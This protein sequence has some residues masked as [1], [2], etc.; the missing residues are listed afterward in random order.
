MNVLNLQTRLSTLSLPA[1]MGLP[2]ELCLESG[3][4]RLRLPLLK[5]PGAYPIVLELV[6]Q[7]SRSSWEGLN[8]SPP[9]SAQAQ[10]RPHQ[11]QD[12]HPLGPPFRWQ[13]NLESRLT[14]D[15]EGFTG[16]LPGEPPL[17]FDDP[18]RRL[19]QVGGELRLPGRFATLTRRED[20]L[21]LTRWGTTT[22]QLRHW[23]FRWRDPHEPLWLVGQEDAYGRSMPYLLDRQGQLSEL[24]QPFTQRKL[25]LL[26]REDG[27]LERVM[28]TLPGAPAQLVAQLTYSREGYLEQVRVHGQPSWQLRS[29]R[30]GGL[31]QLRREGGS[32]CSPLWD[33]QGRCHAL[34]RA[35]AETLFRVNYQPSLGLTEVQGSDGDQLLRRARLS[36]QVTRVWPGGIQER[37]T[38]DPLGRPVCWE[39]PPD[40]SCQLLYDEAGNLCQWEERGGRRWRLEH[41]H[42]HRVL[43]CETPTLR[44]WTVERQA[45]GLPIMLVPPS[46]ERRPLRLDSEGH[47]LSGQSASGVPW[48]HQRSADATVHTLQVGE[49]TETFQLSSR[50]ELLSRHRAERLLTRL[51]YDDAGRPSSLESPLRAHFRYDEWGR[52]VT[53]QS[54]RGGHWQLRYNPEG[55]LVELQDPLRYRLRFEWNSLGQL[56]RMEHGTTLLVAVTYEASGAI[57]TI[58]LPG[59]IPLKFVWEAS[60]QL[61]QFKLGTHPWQ[62]PLPGW[63]SGGQGERRSSF[64]PRTPPLSPLLAPLEQGAAQVSGSSE[65]NAAGLL[66]KRLL[67]D[68]L[69]ERW[70]YDGLGNPL[71]RT[72]SWTDAKQ[73]RAVPILEERWRWKE[74]GSLAVWEGL[75]LSPNLASPLASWKRTFEH[76]RLSRV[77]RVTVEGNQA[78]CPVRQQEQ[79]IYDGLG[80]LSLSPQGSWRYSDE[81]QLEA[82]GER[83]WSWTSLGSWQTESWVGGFLQR[84]SGFNPGEERWQDSRSETLKVTRSPEGQLRGLQFSCVTLK[85]GGEWPS[86]GPVS[87][88]GWKWTPRQ[89]APLAQPEPLP[90]SWLPGEQPLPRSAAHPPEHSPQPLER[91]RPVGI[92]HLD[93]VRQ[94]LEQRQKLAVQRLISQPASH[95]V[96]VGTFW[97]AWS[98]RAAWQL[99]GMLKAW[100]TASEDHT[101]GSAQLTELAGR[102]GVRPQSPASSCSAEPCTVTFQT[103]WTLGAVPAWKAPPNDD[104]TA[105]HA[106][107]AQG[108]GVL[109]L[110]QP[111]TSET[112]F[113][114]EPLEREER[115]QQ[116]LACMERPVTWDE[117]TLALWLLGLGEDEHREWLE[118][119]LSWAAQLVLH[120]DQGMEACPTRPVLAPSEE[121]LAFGST[122][123][124]V[125][126]ASPPIAALLTLLGRMTPT[127]PALEVYVCHS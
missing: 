20:L 23:L 12:H 95:R 85:D 86:P 92:T 44:R 2:L 48:Q 11:A 98:V 70:Q 19:E 68:G 17:L 123:K 63:S 64:L 124:G 25:Q 31:Q 43:R 53:Y 83:H 26:R 126:P 24:R 13:L 96:E 14:A 34:M 87:L 56:L 36:Q 78:G 47:R 61:R 80:R 8:L 58:T 55:Q 76:N 50:G 33:D 84:L 45:D 111:W 105:P 93:E 59:G 4:L 115:I 21:V 65:W 88:Y 118:P 79:Y 67:P 110:R 42:A 15:L 6:G 125:A 120:L 7:S 114:A 116:F 54:P 112:T 97:G 60:G 5:L 77:T 10:V 113:S 22:G 52:C 51:T 81:G 38:L 94:K 90:S 122:L 107:R 35:E 71:V 102:E 91:P 40:K 49:Q 66:A 30:A 27:Q 119:E 121:Q 62:R 9:S 99:R 73:S 3:Q 100:G 28:L 46:G 74:Q 103:G 72:L 82:V 108:P 75:L 57:S 18:H 16:T 37:L 117:P 101:T 29:D 39:F 104:T 32:A 109:L 41:D 89:E 1:F 69:E 106:R 127:L